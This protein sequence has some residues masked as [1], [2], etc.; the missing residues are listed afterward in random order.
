VFARRAREAV[1]LLLA[2]H[3]GLAHHGFNSLPGE[4][5]VWLAQFEVDAASDQAARVAAQQF[6][7]RIRAALARYEGAGLT[8]GELY[9]V[10][11]AATTTS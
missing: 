7:P 5:D 1:T 3:L 2:E 4:P 6:G 10:R 11:P 8:V 9:E